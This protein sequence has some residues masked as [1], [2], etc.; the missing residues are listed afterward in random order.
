M[1]FVFFNFRVCF[2]RDDPDQDELVIQDHLISLKAQE[3]FRS[4]SS[5]SLFF[6]CVT[7][8]FCSFPLSY[9]LTFFS[10]LHI[11][12]ECGSIPA[13]ILQRPFSEDTS[14]LRNIVFLQISLVS[15]IVKFI[16]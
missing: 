16:F 10:T 7:S 3:S 8:V 2:F 15:F 12:F 5:R 1:T 4:Y 6:L 14:S 11:S 9:L 13:E